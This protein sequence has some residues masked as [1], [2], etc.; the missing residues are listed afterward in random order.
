MTRPAPDSSPLLDDWCRLVGSGQAEQAAGIALLARWAEPH[1]AYHTTAHLVAV[2]ARLDEL[3]GGRRR[4]RDRGGLRRR[5]AGGVVARRRVRPATGRQRGS[6]CRPGRGHA[7][8]A[9]GRRPHRRGGGSAGLAHRWSPSGRGRHRRRR[10][11]AMPTWPCWPPRRPRT[12]D[13]PRR[14][15]GSTTIS[16]T[17]RSARVGRRS[18]GICWP[19]PACTPPPPAGA[20]GNRRLVPIWPPSWLGSKE[21][22]TGEG[23]SLAGLSSAREHLICHASGHCRHGVTLRGRARGRDA[24]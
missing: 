21:V 9:G 20:V 19:G 13:T 5:Q 16:P 24:A 1:R 8:R 6:Q 18:C 15:G 3:A 17:R 2:L 14:C 4:R 10:R 22:T 11:C 12:A 7:D 23:K